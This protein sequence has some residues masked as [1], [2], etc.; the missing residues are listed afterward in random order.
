M[1]ISEYLVTDDLTVLLGFIGVSVF[2]LQNLYKPQPLVHPILLGRQSDAGR[3]RHPGESA[4]YRHYGTGQMGRLAV[5][6]DKDVDLVDDFVKSQFESPR[7]LWSTKI[8]NG[9]LK[10]RISA[11][12]A[13]I[14]RLIPEESSVLLLLNDSLEF[15][16]ADLALAKHSIA[17]ITLSSRKLL[18]RVLE[19]HPPSAIIV[20]ADFLPHLLELIYDAREHHHKIIVVGQSGTNPTPKA[21]REV[22]IINWAQVE[23]DGVQVNNA[24]PLPTVRPSDPFTLIFYETPFGDLQGVRFTHSNFTSGVTAIRLLFPPSIALSSLDT[25]VSGHSLSTPFG[26]AVA[27]MALYEC[28]S[29]ATMD[30]TR[31]Y[32]GHDSNLVFKDLSHDVKDVLSATKFPI[33]S[34]TV[35]FVHPE[36][37]HDISTSIISRAKK[38]FLM[39]SFGWRHKL[40]ALTEGFSSKEGLWDRT[41]FD[42]AREYVMGDMA[43]TL[44]AAIVSGGPFSN[45]ALA[46][47]RI[48]L[49]VPLVNA[50]IHPSAT[51]PL[52]A[53]H[54][55][56]LQSLPSAEG[57]PAHVGPP[58]VNVEVKLTGVQDAEVERGSDPKGEVVVRGP[59]VGVL[60]PRDGTE[61][62]TDG[63][64]WVKTA[65]IARVM[66]NGAF[67]VIGLISH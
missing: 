15:V 3:V 61:T 54:A 2:L 51:G 43:S 17:S 27:Y 24:A 26:R 34:P 66:T 13:G 60:L 7:T 11:F 28:A 20:G 42:G 35:L 59:P 19:A 46:P 48:A 16:I 1:T 53:T 22:E 14:S 67:K 49:S 33:S 6:P 29:F 56:D 4:I 62:E 32:D 37:L 64:G 63:E 65:E 57:E 38:S 36:H 23:A 52:F 12:G 5:R 45:D 55:F 39:Y 30:S 9:Q 41:V 40:A 10:E 31:M 50:H 21:A 25:I 47:A 8:T 58:S 44:K 18:S